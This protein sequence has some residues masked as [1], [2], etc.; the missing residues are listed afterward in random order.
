MISET[1]IYFP[2]FLASSLKSLG[3]CG[4]NIRIFEY[5][6]IYLDKYIHSSEY[7]LFFPKQIYLDIHLWSVYT[8]KYI[9]IFIR[10][11]SIIANIF[12]FSAFPNLFFLNCKKIVKWE[13]NLIRLILNHFFFLNLF[14]IAFPSECRMAAKSTYL[15]IDIK[16]MFT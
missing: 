13:N 16:S 14:C 3:Q 8:N 10:P 7:S 11:I 1:Q 5:I 4:M 15:V 6:S 2:L 9:Q 12:E